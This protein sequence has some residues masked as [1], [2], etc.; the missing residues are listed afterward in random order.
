MTSLDGVGVTVIRHDSENRTLVQGC[1]AQGCYRRDV[2][3]DGIS[4][5]QQL[6]V[7]TYISN[8]CRQWIA[9][10]CHASKLA[11]KKRTSVQLLSC[12]FNRS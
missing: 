6:R 5:M 7:L 8:K 12:L 2:M 10:E 1:E 4:D 3:Y 9:Y 11:S